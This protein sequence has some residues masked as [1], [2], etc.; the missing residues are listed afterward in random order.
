MSGRKLRKSFEI[1]GLTSTFFENFRV[2]NLVDVD[3]IFKER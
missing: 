3:Q 2:M 1:G